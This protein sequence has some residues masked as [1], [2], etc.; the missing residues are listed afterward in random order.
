MLGWV[1]TPIRGAIRRFRE[2]TELG[3]WYTE[4]DSEPVD[5]RVVRRGTVSPTRRL[6]E[7][8]LA[9]SWRTSEPNSDLEHIGDRLSGPL[10]GPRS[11]FGHDPLG[12]VLDG[13]DSASSHEQVIES[14]L[15]SLA[16]VF[17]WDYAS[18]WNVDASADALQFV[19]DC[20]EGS[21]QVRATFAAHSLGRGEELPGSAWRAREPFFLPVL[22]EGDTSLRL[23]A[24]IE[25]GMCTAM[26][27]PLANRGQIFGVVEL[28][29]LTSREFDSVDQA[30]VQDGSRLA[31]L[32]IVRSAAE[33]QLLVAANSLR[34]AVHRLSSLLSESGAVPPRTSGTPYPIGSADLTNQNLT[35]LARTVDTMASQAQ[36]LIREAE[37]TLAQERAKHDQRLTQQI[38]RVAA[39]SAQAVAIATRTLGRL[40]RDPRRAPAT[41]SDLLW[42]FD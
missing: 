15:F 7:T 17:D 11:R 31:S 20:G 14:T 24:C 3:D 16:S 27:L 9:L 41:L 2:S 23:R 40:A 13:L 29:S 36:S 25:A 8:Q 10:P 22:S 30:W 6:D 19:T 1:K 39:R 37:Y 12:E 34:E 28:M 35:E 21:D 18:Y 4:T 42:N 26:A 38:R 32:A 5:T 33:D